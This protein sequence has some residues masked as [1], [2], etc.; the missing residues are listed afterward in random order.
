MLHPKGAFGFECTL[1]RVIEELKGYSD[2]AIHRLLV[3]YYGITARGALSEEHVLL[4]AKCKALAE[5]LPSLKEHGHRVLIFSQWTAMLDILEWA[6][7]VIGV[8]Y[9]RLDGST[10]ITERQTIVDTFN[11][12]PSIFACLLSTRAGGQG[13]NLIGAD[14][15][16]IH[17]MDCNPQ[18]DRQAED[19]CH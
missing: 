18:M 9:L 16:V 13:L 19:R 14:T 1:D 5:L 8:T 11:N 4:S 15:V 3:Y 2:F 17:D 7:D 12:D 6:L 10:Q